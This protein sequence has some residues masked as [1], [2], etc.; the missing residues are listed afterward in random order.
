[1][2]RRDFLK[3]SPVLAGQ[4]FPASAAPVAEALLI[5]GP[6]FLKSDD[7]AE[8]AR[9]HRR[10]GYSAAYCPPVR[11][12]EK[13]RLRAIEAAYAK[14]RVVIAEV[15][16]WKNLLDIDPA[17][18]KEN[19]DYVVERMAIAD[20]IGARCCVDIAGSYS[21]KSWYGPHPKNLSK[22]GFDATV[23]NCRRILDQV[24]PKRS[25]FT[26]EVMGW[27]HPDSPDSYLRLIKAVDRK[28]FAVHLD[29]CN[30]INSP[31][32]FYNSGAL[33]DE[34]FRK[35]GPHIRSCHAKD[36]EWIVELNL[37]FLEV[38]PGRGQVDYHSYLRGLRSLQ[39]PAP[40]MLEHLKT[41]D[42]YRE[43]FVY[44]KKIAG[45]LNYPLA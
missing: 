41:A 39:T 35:L 22:E 3:I 28:G 6:V 43:G 23:E 4:A 32:K 30:A 9:E 21:E 2:Q 29:V 1:M 38:I 27:I 5:G 26:V 15:G 40:L 19:F 18:R 16:A 33:I 45:E 17:K 25:F 31:S 36:L 13:E 20:E 8:L 42:E 7:P 37:H 14:E 10:L 34:W 12:H 44:I 11:I 24:K